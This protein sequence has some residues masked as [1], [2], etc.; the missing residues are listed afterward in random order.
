MLHRVRE[1]IEK[2]RK[3]YEEREKNGSMTSSN[4][5]SGSLNA[6]DDVTREL[7][8][9]SPIEGVWVEDYKIEIFDP[10][11]GEDKV[12]EKIRRIGKECVEHSVAETTKSISERRTYGDVEVCVLQHMMHHMGL[13]LMRPTG[14]PRPDA[15]VI[16]KLL[17][18]VK[19]Q[20]TP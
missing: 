4:I 1:I 14:E 17:D 2:L 3:D 9:I 13:C 10:K 18:L 5:A 19:D 7:D 11:T 6:L 12:F 20:F 15:P 16:Q 8:K